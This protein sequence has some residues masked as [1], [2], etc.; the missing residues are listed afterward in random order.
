MD[1][2]EIDIWWILNKRSRFIKDNAPI[3]NKIVFLYNKFDTGEDE[4]DIK[5]REVKK[6]DFDEK[7]NMLETFGVECKKI[8]TGD[9]LISSIFEQIN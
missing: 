4:E 9:N 6:Q 3:K 2:S 5:K 8:D 7:R 1:F